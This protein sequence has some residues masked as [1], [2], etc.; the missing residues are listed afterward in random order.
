MA[1]TALVIL[2]IFCMLVQ[3]L[4]AVLTHS[5]VKEIES[6][7]EQIPQWPSSWLLLFL[8]VWAISLKAL[9]FYTPSPLS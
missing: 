4:Q 8:K 1:D 6:V 9:S 2:I 5:A 7:P 3:A